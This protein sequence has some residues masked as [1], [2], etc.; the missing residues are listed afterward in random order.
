MIMQNVNSGLTPT[1]STG[2]VTPSGAGDHSLS[3]AVA[4]LGDVDVLPTPGLNSRLCPPE[5]AIST[6]GIGS[7][8][9]RNVEL[10]EYCRTRFSFPVQNPNFC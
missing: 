2:Y 9:D 4:A 7:I 3:P 8:T 1:Q 10:V 5:Q 6:N